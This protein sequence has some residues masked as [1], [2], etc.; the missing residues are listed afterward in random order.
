M[1]L[2]E[3]SMCSA[4][5]ELYFRFVR[6]KLSRVCCLC[7]LL[8]GS[9]GPVFNARYFSNSAGYVTNARTRHT[10][11]PSQFLSEPS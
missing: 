2:L 10:S 7:L 5:C 1:L 6:R 4:S 11:C 9:S 3:L 8:A